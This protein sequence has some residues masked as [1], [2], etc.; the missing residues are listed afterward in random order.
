MNDDELD[1]RLEQIRSRT[2]EASTRSVLNE[3]GQSAAAIT[4]HDQRAPARRS[5]VHYRLGWMLGIVG[6]AAALTAGMTLSAYYLKMPPFQGLPDDSLR[7]TNFIPVEYTTN[8]GVPVACKVFLEFE[9]LDYD[10]AREVDVA[11]DARDWSGFGAS[12]YAK[13]PELP[14]A[15]T[16]SL[17][18]QDE[19]SEEIVTAAFEFAS[20][21]VPSL[22]F[23]TD[24]TDAPT[25]SAVATTC[26]PDTK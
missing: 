8:N 13:H 24:D 5:R 3:L 2:S 11:I 15:P 20:G 17:S 9:R 21:V 25:L 18:P 6:L 16:D 26:S 12:L 10:G 4:A 14:A 22:T 23:F 7:T 19:I 1:T